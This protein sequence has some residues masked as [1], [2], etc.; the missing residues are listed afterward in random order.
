MIE[1]GE[2][3]SVREKVGALH[4]SSSQCSHTYY[5]PVGSRAEFGV[6]V[7]AAACVTTRMTCTETPVCE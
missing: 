6:S 5:P 2:G 4:C 1:D 3:T 7:E